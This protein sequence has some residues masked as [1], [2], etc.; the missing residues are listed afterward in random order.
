MSCMNHGIARRGL[1]S[2]ES[3]GS[4]PIC[5]VLGVGISITEN[6]SWLRFGHE[7]QDVDRLDV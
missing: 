3:A 1:A 6:L 4:A 7:P 5:L 2:K